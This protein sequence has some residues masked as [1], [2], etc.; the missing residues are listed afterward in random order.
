MRYGVRRRLLKIGNSYSVIVPPLIRMRMCLYKRILL[1]VVYDDE[2]DT[3]TVTR[4]Q[5]QP[6]GI[7]AEG[8]AHGARRLF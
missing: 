6:A 2:T 1:D 7:S 4:A 5:P 3:I 8:H